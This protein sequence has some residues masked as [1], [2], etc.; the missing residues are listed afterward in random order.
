MESG[1]GYGTKIDMGGYSDYI[2]ASPN[3]DCVLVGGRGTH[4]QFAIVALRRAAAEHL[5]LDL[6]EIPEP[7]AA[8][9][10]AVDTLLVTK[11]FDEMDYAV[12]VYC[13]WLPKT[14]WLF[15]AGNEVL[16]GRTV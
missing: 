13:M 9:S 1:K 12:E 3:G 10:E 15:M 7:T 16:G 11:I 4:P 5:G 2:V 6:W 8:Q 14:G